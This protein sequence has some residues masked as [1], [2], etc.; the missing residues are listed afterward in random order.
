[1]RATTLA[2]LV[3]VLAIVLVWAPAAPA[4]AQT[5]GDPQRGEVT[6]RCHTDEHQPWVAFEVTTTVRVAYTGSFR[7]IE[8]VDEPELRLTEVTGGVQPLAANSGAQVDQRHGTALVWGQVLFA[9]GW[10]WMPSHATCMAEY[11]PYDRQAA[12]AP[13]PAPPE[14]EA[15]TPAPTGDELRYGVR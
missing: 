11:D 5:A 13:E 7:W 14:A 1:M 6:L 8:S 15:S 2:R 10:D 4:G 9:T 3:V 12:P